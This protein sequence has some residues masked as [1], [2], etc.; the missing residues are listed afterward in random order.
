MQATETGE[1]TQLSD[2]VEK[3]FREA[4]INVLKLQKEPVLKNVK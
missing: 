2:L 3:D 1:K 4:I